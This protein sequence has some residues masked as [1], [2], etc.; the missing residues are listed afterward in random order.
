MLLGASCKKAAE[1]PRSMLTFSFSLS[2]LWIVGKGGEA[3]W[4]SGKLSCHYVLGK[5]SFVM[6]GQA[7]CKIVSFLDLTSGSVS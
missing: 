6:L 4:V 7:A 5:P 3:L 1:A 2:V